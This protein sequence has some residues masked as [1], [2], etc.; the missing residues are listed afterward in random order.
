MIASQS[1]G[2]SLAPSSDIAGSASPGAAGF[3]R[4]LVTGGLSG[5][6]AAI[7]RQLRGEGVEVITA[8]IAEGADLLVNV[9]SSED[10]ATAQSAAGAV[11]ILVNS[12]GIVGPA[13]PTVEVAD[14][15]WAET[16]AVNLT[17]TFKM[18]RAFASGM[19]SRGWGRIVN[20]ASIAGKEG[21]PNLAAYSVSKAG[22]IALTKCLGKELAQT[23][24][25]VNAVAPAVIETPM[26]SETPAE[27]LNYMIA[28]IP[29]GRAG[30]ADEVAQ[31]VSWLASDR[32]SF[33]TG[34][35][36]DISGGRA[37]Y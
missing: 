2:E 28:K 21:N 11:D 23:G 15:E 7:V 16:M 1:G 22:V 31:L 29:M 26:N 3:R 24:V 35:T 4:A 33:S 37:T 25:L 27:T 9:A 10:V 8:D 14:D 12:A 6:G 34:A 17:G 5:I 19:I 30:R 18:C 32:C 20:V 36:Y 13:K